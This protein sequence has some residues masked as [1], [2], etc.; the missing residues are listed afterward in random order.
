[1][2]EASNHYARLGVARDATSEEIRAAYFEAARRLHPDAN[3]DPQAAEDFL[4]VQEAYEVLSDDNKRAQYDA[5]LQLQE[6]AASAI[7]INTLYSRMN[8]P[9][10]EEPQLVYVMLEL[11]AIPEPAEEEQSPP[12]NICLV[13]DRSTSMQ[14][15]RMEMV[16]ANAIQMIRQMRPQDT[17]SVVVFS[18]RAEVLVPASRV[19]EGNKIESRI[20]MI[21][22]SGGTEIYR[23]L[24]AGISQLRRAMNSNTINHL[25]LLTDGRTYGDEEACLNLA[26]QAAEEG[27]GISGLGIGHEWNDEFLDKL[28][29]ASGGSSMYISAP[30]DLHKY[31]EQQ[32]AS[33]EKVYA[34]RVT[35]DLNLE[36]GVQLRYAFRLQPEAGE[37]PV[38]GPMRL[39]NIIQNKSMTLLFE[40]LLDPIPEGAE[41]ITL[42][43]GNIRMEIPSH[44]I[45][46]TRM[47]VSFSRMVSDGNEVD[48]PHPAIVQAMSRLTLYRLQAKASLEAASGQIASASRHLQY[49]ATHLLS[50]GERDLAHTVLVEAEHLQQTHEFTNEGN[51][52]IKYGT[53]ALLLPPGME[54]P[55]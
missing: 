25:I 20:N 17:I 14:G 21:L 53:R 6:E 40:F 22:P 13:L 48:R 15:A 7:K 29:A 55:Q 35:L 46:V 27:I 39:G 43:H 41:K 18:D 50:Q 44:Q 51:K 9:R 1:M 2:T 26:A 30:R 5:H 8:I 4:A 36:A 32:L 28:V 12:L 33:F 42:A 11:I 37:L 52:R 47:R 16:K 38:K 34:E 24:E 54:Y 23:G 10:L 49:L 3:P 45:P 31:F 19:A